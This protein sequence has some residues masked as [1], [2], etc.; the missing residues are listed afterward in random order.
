MDLLKITALLRWFIT[1]C[2]LY[3]YV[4]PVYAI[5][6]PEALALLGGG[7]VYPSLLLI[8]AVTVL[9][10]YIWIK[11]KLYI[12]CRRYMASITCGL[13]ILSFCLSVPLINQWLTKNNPVNPETFKEWE[14]SESK[15]LVIDLRAAASF[16]KIHL[17]G[18]INL[19]GGAGLSA[20]LKNNPDKKIILI[21]ESGL[22]SASPQYLAHI[23][24]LLIQKILDENRLFYSPG[25]MNKLLRLGEK[26]P[27]SIIINLPPAYAQ[28]LI[29]N[30]H[31]QEIKWVANKNP[32]AENNF[33]S[34][35]KKMLNK[36][37]TP[38][39]QSDFSADEVSEKLRHL[40]VPHLYFSS[41]TQIEAYSLTHLLLVLGGIFTIFCPIRHKELYR[42]IMTEPSASY[43]WRNALLALMIPIPVTMLGLFN[44]PVPFD[45]E[46]YQMN[47]GLPNNAGYLVAAYTCFGIVFLMHLVL[48]NRTRLHFLQNKLT[49]V[50]APTQYIYLLRRPTLKEIFIVSGLIYTSYLL[51]ISLS[52]IYLVSVFL[53]VPFLVD[54]SLCA[55]LSQFK[56][57]SSRVFNVL[58]QCGY[59]CKP[60]GNTFVQLNT[61]NEL[62][63]ARIH[64]TIDKASNEL[65]LFTGKIVAETNKIQPA[66]TAKFV[67]TLQLQESHLSYYSQVVRNLLL[68]FQQDMKIN[69]DK[70]GNILAVKLYHNHNSPRVI[71]RNLILKHHKK[72]PGSITEPRF[73]STV[74][75][76]IFAN[77][78][79]LM[80]DV[81][82]SR[83]DK[84]GGQLLA[85]HKLGILIKSNDKSQ[86][87]FLALSNHI[88]I[89]QLF[90]KSIFSANKLFVWVR[91]KVSNLRFKLAIDS[92]LQDYHTF[93]VPQT[94]LRLAKLNEHL[95]QTQSVSQLK[96]IIN[97][98]LTTLCNESAMWQSYSSLL[99]QHAFLQLQAEAEKT[100]RDLSQLMT[101]A[102]DTSDVSSPFYT[103][104]TKQNNTQTKVTLKDQANLSYWQQA[105][106]NTEPVRT[107]IREYQLKEWQLISQLL[108][109]LTQLLTLPIS[110]VYLTKHDLSYLSP[111]RS[112]IIDLLSYR[113]QT[114]HIQN[115]WPFPPTCSLQ[116]LERVFTPLNAQQDSSSLVSHAIR[117]AGNQS[118]VSGSA[119]IYRDKLQLGKLARGSILIADNLLPEQIIACQHIKGIILKNGGYLSHTSIIAREKNILLI[120]RFNI[121]TIP[122]KAKLMIHHDNQVTILSEKL[123]DWD[124]I[125]GIDTSSPI[126][127]K[128]QRSAI[129]SQ[130]GYNLPTTIILKHDT[131]EK[132]Y[133]L[134]SL[135]KLNKISATVWQPYFDELKQLLTLLTHEQASIIIR[136]S[137]N[138]EDSNEYSYA[139][140][141]YSQPHINSVEALIGAITAAW[142]NMLDR[143]DV[144]KKYTGETQISL[145]LMLQT[146]IKGQFGGVLFTESSTPE[147]MQVEIAQGGAEGV[148]EGSTALTSVYIDK[149]GQTSHAFGEESMLCHEQYQA[150]YQLGRELETLFGAPQDVE[151][152]IAEEQ[153]YIIQSRDITSSYSG[154]ITEK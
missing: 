4:S 37:D 108:E 48:P 63:L 97:R 9:C 58:K 86:E 135:Y 60:D 80:L 128:A 47:T 2:F 14:Q 29:K 121:S 98:A 129:M 144:I 147:F 15:P 3:G 127:N 69:L 40:N 30:Q 8:G 10:R 124:F 36:H 112:K 52:V 141:F 89:D 126:G 28:D 148:T 6:P 75:Q 119:V 31:T 138:L 43:K 109:K 44:L 32:I 16:S 51:L 134:A 61:L 92:I 62:A 116:D 102:T 153:I 1:S 53:L 72:L 42:S 140:I 13:L 70:E 90:E 105:F 120:A 113:Y 87:Q 19:P 123:L 24:K 82:K 65:G 18:S 56:N 57:T 152:V 110:L 117:V 22:R 73:T 77:P 122:D 71:S 46:L 78:T 38:I 88:Y 125:D 137:S 23:D 59:P 7:I 35:F 95:H 66:N 84:K 45:V 67:R 114:W 17:I 91:K 103:F 76:D 49:H 34:A 100:C 94:E 74:F 107:A 21:C 131:V 50:F 151:W 54:L 33:I 143:A 39:I 118:I 83:W 130:Y 96:R 12:V 27:A 142:Q 55:F 64:I 41:P 132:I 25:G 146:Y 145:N 133:Q 85:L 154:C 150:L 111:Q 81:L 139:G 11:S 93:I 101:K 104:S 149:N 20:Y 26:T 5:P 115:E 106:L 99:H 79:P 136:S 68:F